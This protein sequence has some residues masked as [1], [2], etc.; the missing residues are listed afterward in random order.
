MNV[1]TR[2]TIENLKLNKAR[3]I[4]TVI[5]II[6]SMAM[7]TAVSVLVTSSQSYLINSAKAGYGNWY[8][9]ILS[10]NQNAVEHIQKNEDIEEYFALHTIGYARMDGIVNPYKPYIYV[11]AGDEGF[12]RNM[13]VNI[14]SGRLPENR[15]EIIIPEHLYYNGGVF[16]ELGQQ[17]TL[18][19]GLRVD[20]QM[21]FLFQQNQLDGEYGED[22]LLSGEQTYTIVGYYERPSFENWSAPGYTALTYSDVPTGNFSDIYY[23]P[24]D[25][26][27][28]FDIMDI[29]TDRPFNCGSITNTNLLRFSGNSM[30]DGYN[31]VLYGLGRVLILIIVF[32]SIALIYNAFSISVSERAKQFGLMSSIGATKK[33]LRT[34][35]VTEALI[36]C[37]VGIPVGMVSGIC[38]IAVTLQLTQ[39]MF[40]LGFKELSLYGAQDVDFAMKITPLAIIAAVL[41]ALGTALI[42]AYIP[43]RRAASVSAID[44][45][46]Q[47]KDI[48]DTGDVIKYNPVVHR[49]F[50]FEAVLAGRNFRRSRRRYRATVI[51]LFMSVVLFV[52]AYSFGTSLK[53]GVTNVLSNVDYDIMYSYNNT[54]G[55]LPDVY[56]QYDILRNTEGVTKSGYNFVYSGV[57]LTT[58]KG[59]VIPTE[60]TRGVSFR[61]TA[62]SVNLVFVDDENYCAWLRL[63]GYNPD[64]YKDMDIPVAF[65]TNIYQYYD[66]TREKY[67]DLTMLRKTGVDVGINAGG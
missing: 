21:C 59:N 23:I 6:L 54:K 65:T 4:V 46:R 67:T 20:N 63:N 18:H 64:D 35:V 55:D 25:I 47:S 3:T 52:S 43:A 14:T 50:G 51:S 2:Y 13:P 42:S 38:G 57:E 27:K 16:T 15:N 29:Y 30:E 49:M 1:L 12:F 45:I 5:G 48:K 39:K 28:T 24:K 41:L 60:N 11:A 17:L 31:R 37:C 58:E 19:T 40:R 33:Q 36:L 61:Q 7:F 44:A 8:G 22:L 56:R 32:A 9:I 26:A 53:N 34:S 66:E 62:V 10:A